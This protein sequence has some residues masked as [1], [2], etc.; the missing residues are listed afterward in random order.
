[1]KLTDLAPLIDGELIGDGSVEIR[2]VA[3]IDPVDEIHAGEITL[4]ENEQYFL[5]AQASRA[6]AIVV[7]F[8]PSA[9]TKPLIRVKKTTLA[10]AKMLTIFHPPER[11]PA[12]VHP[13]AVVGRNVTLGDAVHIGANAVVKDGASIGACSVVDAGAVIGERVVIG[14]DS[15]VHSNATLYREVRLGDR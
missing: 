6:S 11:P 4:A 15:F 2:G 13:T 1:M 5:K 8:S 3:P 9:A 14:A 12:G 7:S 10:L